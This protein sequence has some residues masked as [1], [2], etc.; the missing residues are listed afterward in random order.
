MKPKY[1]SANYPGISAKLRYSWR[2]CFWRCT[3]FDL[4]W[5]TSTSQSISSVGNICHNIIDTSVNRIEAR[6]KRMHAPYN[7]IVVY[8]ERPESLPLNILGIHGAMEI[9]KCN[10]ATETRRLSPSS[11]PTKYR[12][13]LAKQTSGCV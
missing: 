1:L 11:F 10:V 8:I 6:R 7:S 2:C 4:L 12:K 3:S 5:R 13:G 9:S